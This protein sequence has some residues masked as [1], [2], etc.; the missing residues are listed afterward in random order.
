MARQ[1]AVLENQARE[2]TQAEL[3][4]L[5]DEDLDAL[6]GAHPPD[7]EFEAAVQI[8]SDG[9]LDRALEGKLDTQT[10]RRMYRQRNA[11]L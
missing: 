10:I 7:P 5:S 2:R 1:L 4:V 6:I 11:H 9:E 3:D 8:L